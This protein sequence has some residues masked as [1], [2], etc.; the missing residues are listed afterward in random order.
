MREETSGFGWF[1]IMYLCIIGATVEAMLSHASPFL[2]LS[3]VPHALTSPYGI[4]QSYG[5]PHWQGLCYDTATFLHSHVVFFFLMQSVVE[6]VRQAFKKGIT[7]K[8]GD[9]FYSV[10]SNKQ[11]Q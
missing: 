8:L 2:T 3:G 9:L 11:T 10:D 7:E 4:P 6:R 1:R 5:G